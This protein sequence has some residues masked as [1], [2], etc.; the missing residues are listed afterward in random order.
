MRME[1]LQQLCDK[2]L[3]PWLLFALHEEVA[4]CRVEMVCLLSRC[5]LSHCYSLWFIHLPSYIN[6]TPSKLKILRVGFE[7]LL[8][9]QEAK[10][11]P[12]DEVDTTL[13]KWNTAKQ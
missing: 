4:C 5:L 10:L 1:L 11:Q 13:S 8:K 12:P 6:S 2:M 9:M 3:M 7:V